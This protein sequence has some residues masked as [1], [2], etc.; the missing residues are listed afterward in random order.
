MQV[1]ETLRK[2]YR[3]RIAKQTGCEFCK[4]EV[5]QEQECKNISSNLW[6]VLT[7]KYP[8][9]DGNVMIVPKRH[10]TDLDQISGEEWT[11]FHQVL[12]KTQKVLAK[13]FDTTSFNV[14]INIGEHSGASIDHL[15][16]Q[17][18]PRKKK[19]MNA[20]NVFCDLYVITVSPQDLKKQI[21]ALG[22]IK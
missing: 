17:V 13:I 6:R 10:I 9:M 21:E 22:D 19:I 14:N 1:L 7:N 12:K 5:A 20:T 15:H 8:Y 16:W 3:K 2:T 11:D 4:S 18:I